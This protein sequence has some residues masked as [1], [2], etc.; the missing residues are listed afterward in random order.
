M[1]ICVINVV[2]KIEINNSAFMI[3][4]YIDNQCFSP[5]FA[6]SYPLNR[7]EL[8]WVNS[9]LLNPFHLQRAFCLSVCLSVFGGSCPAHVCMLGHV[10]SYRKDFVMSSHFGAPPA[11]QH[12]SAWHVVK[13]QL[14]LGNSSLFLFVGPGNEHS[15]HFSFLLIASNFYC[16]LHLGLRKDIEC[17]NLQ[18]FK[19]TKS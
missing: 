2:K 10:Q 14:A 16:S 13:H 1:Y 19:I 12:S 4:L 17:S 15:K 3:N 5:S 9:F 7:A 18:V 8:G 6:F 11:P